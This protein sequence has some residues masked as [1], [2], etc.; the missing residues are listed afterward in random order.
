ME[1]GKI[2]FRPE[3]FWDVDPKTIDPQKHSTY[4]IE[5]I[6]DLGDLD[7]VKWMS[8]FYP[9]KAIKDAL[10]NSRVVHDKS[11]LLWSLVF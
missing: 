4:I 1:N 2:E 3:L 8:H 10:Q 5:R 11:K 9:L 6:L 7:E